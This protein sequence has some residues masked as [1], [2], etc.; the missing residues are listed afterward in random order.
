VNEYKT[1]FIERIERTPAS[2]SYRFNVPNAFSFVAGQ[3]M[4]V[5][6]GQGLIHPLSLSSCPEETNFIEFTKRM[7][8]SPYCKR[9]EDL[10][11]SELIS[12]K[13]PSGA[14]NFDET[15]GNIAMIAGGIGITPIISIL[16][17][18]EKQKKDNCKI[19]LIYGN[20]N[21][22]DIAF[23]DELED[24]KIPGFKLVHVLSDPS[25]V[26]SAYK[27]FV[28]VEIIAKEV[29]DYQNATYMMSGPPVMV[30]AMRKVTATLNIPSEQIRTDIFLG[31]D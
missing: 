17:S 21:R 23:R 28:T 27:G 18:L 30:K 8:G 1:K 6:L 7:T 22:D 31:Y 12:V 24:L 19:T 5:N 25:G 9:L 20:L 13:G 4:F 11:R 15:D 3:Y 16:K 26:E 29:P 2:V 14:F 10:A